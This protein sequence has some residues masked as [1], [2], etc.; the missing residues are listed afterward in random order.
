MR[1]RCDACGK[2]TLLRVYRLPWQFECTACLYRVYW[3][4]ME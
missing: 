4:D 1:I 3:S 2:N